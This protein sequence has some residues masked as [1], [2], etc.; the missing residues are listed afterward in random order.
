MRPFEDRPSVVCHVM[1]AIDGRISGRFFGAGA[2]AGY[3]PYREIWA[4]Y[5]C[6][7]IL[8]GAVTC[9]EIYADGYVSSL[10]AAAK[11]YEREDFLPNSGLDHYV[12]AVDTEGTLNWR[13]AAAHRS[14][15]PEAQIVHVLTENVS[16]SYLAFLREKGVAYLFAGQDQL[17]LGLML[18]KLKEK[19]GIS[20]ILMTGGGV[21][22][23]SFPSAGYLDELSLVIAP[24]AGGDLNVATVFDRSPYLAEGGAMG[25]TLKEVK[26]YG[27]AVH[28]RYAPKNS[29]K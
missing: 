1:S 27:D 3:G 28:L 20:S 14:G 4:R 8:N 9:A 24:A 7:A 2:S 6:D 12:I 23:Y 11:K 21:M 16:D 5:D 13:G 26:Q 29:K 15:Q 25:F 17:D 22:D 10:P 18:C 19:L